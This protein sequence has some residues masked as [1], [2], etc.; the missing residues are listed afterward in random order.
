V[1]FIDRPD[2]AFLSAMAEGEP[3]VLYTLSA[4]DIEFYARVHL[5][6]ETADE[7]DWEL[8]SN[9]REKRLA[10]R[11]MRV[12]VAES[13]PLTLRSV[14][15]FLTGMGCHSVVARSGLEAIRLSKQWQPDVLLLEAFLP[16]ARGSN[17][18]RFVKEL[19]G[20]RQPRTIVLSKEDM[21]ADFGVDGFL[22]KPVAFD[23]IAD[24]VFGA[25]A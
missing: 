19:D 9:V 16:E 8:V 5:L 4:A 7:T 13:D 3:R 20:Q 21:S 24:A 17:F 18:A 2:H 14:T 25:A 15:S 23:R 11:P 10:E 1:L 12:L 22:R 6:L